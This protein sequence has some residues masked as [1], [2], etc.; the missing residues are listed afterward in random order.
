MRRREAANQGRNEAKGKTM[1][2]KKKTAAKGEH[3]TKKMTQKIAPRQG[4]YRQGD[5]LLVPVEADLEAIEQAP[6][7]PRGLV[8]A[9]GES[10][11]HHH[12][13]FGTNAR[14][15]RYRATPGRVVVV[16]SDDGAEVRVVGG[17]SGGVDR[18]TPISLAP[19]HYAVRLQRAYHA[20]MSRRVVD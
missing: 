20:G 4:L 7:D 8:L 16:V 3:M 17:G 18:H 9:E 15:M 2:I 19:G 5:V 13:I 6:V 12:A 1:T 10:S 11:G 14:L